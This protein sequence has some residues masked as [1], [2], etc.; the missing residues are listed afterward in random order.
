MLLIANI[1]AWLNLSL[2]SVQVIISPKICTDV[3]RKVEYIVI[4]HKKGRGG[5]SG[6]SQSGHA[7]MIA[8]EA[9]A[10]SKTVLRIQMEDGCQMTISI[11]KGG[12]EI[13]RGHYYCVL[14]KQTGLQTAGDVFAVSHAR[15]PID[16]QQARPNSCRTNIYGNSTC[17]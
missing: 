17:K 13:F 10:L 16:T 8:G 2:T 5:N 3:S 4:V 6:I 12:V 9:L 15:A 14:E 11:K 7:R 1:D